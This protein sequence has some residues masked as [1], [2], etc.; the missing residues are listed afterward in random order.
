M[1]NPDAPK[2][3]TLNQRAAFDGNIPLVTLAPT[4]NVQEHIKKP[5]IQFN[6][7]ELTKVISKLI[8]KSHSKNGIACAVKF[9]EK[10]IRDMLSNQSN[11]E[12]HAGSKLCPQKF[13]MTKAVLQQALLSA[14]HHRKNSFTYSVIYLIVYTFF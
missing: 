6:T 14:D 8:N 5:V 3:V 10:L 11:W 7:A 2:Y 13:S 1:L 9:I 12:T 4:A